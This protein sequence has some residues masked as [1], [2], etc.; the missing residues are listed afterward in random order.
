MNA[1]NQPLHKDPSFWI[2]AVVLVGAAS[3][4]QLYFGVPWFSQRLAQA[5]PAPRSVQP[6][7]AD[8]GV[9][10]DSNLDL[11]KKTYSWQAP[12]Y[13]PRLLEETPPQV[14]IVPT[15]YAPPSGG[16]GQTRSDKAIGIRMSA[17]FVVQAAYDWT[18]HSRMVWTDPMPAGQFDFIANLSTG[19]LE[20]LQAA[21][22]KQWGLVAERE[23][24]Q[25]NV[26]V[27]KVDH[28]DAPG[29]KPGTT[30]SA[31]VPGQAGSI[32][33]PNV[34]I[35]FLVSYLENTLQLPVVDQTGLT[36]KYDIQIPTIPPGQTADRMERL[37]STFHDQLGLDLV[38]TNAAVEI[39]VV[40]KASQT[41]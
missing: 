8:A 23:T 5:Q 28:A 29:L 37:R 26:V 7:Q 20:A 18:S 35:A 12:K 6:V 9:H 24:R 34:P 41:P 13:M 33:F 27:L 31:P 40:R 1:T 39:L 32:Q 22:K 21:V 2:V 30:S 3:A 10:Q 38:T 17:E 11:R 25:T 4:T 16:W 14:V 36:G 15:E 19:A